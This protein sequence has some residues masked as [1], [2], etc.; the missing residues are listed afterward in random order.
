MWTYQYNFKTHTKKKTPPKSQY[1]RCMASCGWPCRAVIWSLVLI[2]LTRT[3]T[4][5]KEKAQ[6][7]WG[8]LYDLHLQEVS[9]HKLAIW[10]HLREKTNMTQ[11]FET[12][13]P[14]V[15]WSRCTKAEAGT[16]RPVRGI[17]QKL[18]AG[19]GGEQQVHCSVTWTFPLPNL[20]SRALQNKC[21]FSLVML[22]QMRGRRKCIRLCGKRND[23]AEFVHTG[24]HFSL[25]HYLQ[26]Q[27]QLR[28]K[29]E[30]GCL[31]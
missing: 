10:P 18:E 21:I 3:T 14:N 15:S 30:E 8:D 13:E 9:A 23:L 31:F 17:K 12:S 27:K 25:F 1:D 20:R 24:T 26:T 6:V 29:P 28:R 22:L 5:K 16:V 2:F 7:T 19:K 11:C 4:K